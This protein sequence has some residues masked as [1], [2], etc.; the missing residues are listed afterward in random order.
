MIK[1]EACSLVHNQVILKYW[2]SNLRR[3]TRHTTSGLGQTSLRDM[4]AESK[5][6]WHCSQGHILK[7]KMEMYA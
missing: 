1:I 6:R 4:H 3:A 7:N 5:R 2:N